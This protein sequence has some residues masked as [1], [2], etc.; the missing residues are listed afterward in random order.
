MVY[1]Q[2]HKIAIDKW[3]QTNREKYNEI[4]LAGQHKYNLQNKDK[5]K[6]YKQK[7]WAYK[8]E[9]EIFRNILI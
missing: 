5:I 6:I 8:K 3:R 1:T 2:Q 9:T 7:Y 4:C